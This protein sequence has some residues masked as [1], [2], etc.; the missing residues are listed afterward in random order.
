MNSI[1]LEDIT[2]IQQSK[3]LEFLNNDGTDSKNI[4]NTL[5]SFNSNSQNNLKGES[6][7]KV[8][9][10]YTVY[11]EALTQHSSIASEISQ[12]IQ[13]I[14]T[15][16]QNAMNGYDSIDISK[17]DEL[18]QQKTSCESKI[19]SIKNMMSQ[20]K[21]NFKTF[22]YEPVYNN[23]ELQKS[24]DAEI[25]ILQELEKLIQTIENIKE[26]CEKAIAKLNSLI[27]KMSTI[28]S[29]IEQITPS[30]KVQV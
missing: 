29:N 26:I 17:L 9:A 8:R 3:T 18:K 25:K 24:L 21:F 14:I 19:A 23:A 13:S 7:D 28:C 5:K 22:T 16:L 30:D 20:T 1:S 4:S 27:Q 10:K 12:T 11:D 15:E 6:W 2:T